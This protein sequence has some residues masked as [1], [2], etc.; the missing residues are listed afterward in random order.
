MREEDTMRVSHLAK[1][2]MLR[3]VLGLLLVSGIVPIVLGADG[4]PES[5]NYMPPRGQ[6][7]ISL[8]GS[9]NVAYL[10]EYLLGPNVDI[11]SRSLNAAPEA[12]GTFSG[13]S[14]VIGFDRGIVLSSGD[15]GTLNGPNT[16]DNTS[17]HHYRAGDPDLDGLVPG[18]TTYD[19][20]VLT[21]QFRCETASE[22]SFQYVFGSEEYNEWANSQYGDPFGLFL[23]GINIATVPDGCS[24]PGSPVTVN[25]VN[26]GNPYVGSGPNCDCYR[27]ND[28]SDG[29]GAIGTELDGLT[30][31]FVATGVIQAGVNTLKIAIAD[32][33]D[34]VLDS[35]VMIRCQS[36]PC[37]ASLPAGACCVPS[38]LCV[39]LAYPDC[40]AQSG[41]YYGDY[42]PCVPSPCELPTGACCFPEGGCQMTGQAGCSANGGTYQGDGVP[43]SGAA[44]P[45]PTGACCDFAVGWFT[46]EITTEAGC[47]D[48]TW[49]GPDVPCNFEY[50]PGEAFPTGACCN[51]ATGGCWVGTYA[52]C[53]FEW[54]YLTPCSP[55]ICLV[56]DPT[57]ACCDHATGACAITT[58]SACAFEWLGAGAQCSFETCRPPVPTEKTSWGQIKNTYR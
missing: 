51:H 4:R 32:A 22:I 40:T 21:L 15:I 38:G 18:S 57:G 48:G 55:R 14:P 5:T 47:E 50:C 11:I 26:C 8:T 34:H 28:L 33:G 39:T 19:A 49:L 10:V 12:A 7:T 3:A 16:G 42:T 46:C 20:A 58:E 13:A 29:G 31:V 41:N 30:Q 2:G 37:G 43:C 24:N 1:R 9:S 36:F 53:P 45:Q 17:T 52:G 23:N 6:R 27:N 35:T 56:Q 25:S 54:S 44:C